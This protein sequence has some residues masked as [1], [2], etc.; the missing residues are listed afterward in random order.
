[1]KISNSRLRVSNFGFS[2]IEL[3]VIVFIIAVISSISIADFRKGEKRKQ[4]ALAADIVINAIRSAQN[5][6]LSGRNIHRQI[7]PQPNSSC[8]VPQYYS[9]T[10]SYSGQILLQALN[11]NT[12]SCGASPD[13]V[14]TYSLPTN[15]KVD[16]GGL[17]LDGTTA[18]SDMTIQFTP[19]FGVMKAG[20]DGAAAAAF[21]SAA[22]TVL[23][24]DGSSPHTIIVDGVSGR[25]G[26]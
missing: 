4:T 8:L 14:E 19:P 2:L 1:M 18:T 26:E 20:R 15:V 17:T 7:D 24:T 13:T 23:L 9:V 16:S 22:I 6:T 25:I 3:V 12:A 10:I 5:Y 21:N 11:N